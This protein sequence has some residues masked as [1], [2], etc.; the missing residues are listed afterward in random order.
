MIYKIKDN[1]PDTTNIINLKSRFRTQFWNKNANKRN[2]NI[3]KIKDNEKIKIKK[4]EL[5][6]K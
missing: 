1:K 2:V 3:E 5:E 6:K 4:E